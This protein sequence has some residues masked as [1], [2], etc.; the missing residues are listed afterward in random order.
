MGFAQRI[1]SFFLDSGNRALALAFF[2]LLFTMYQGWYTRDTTRRGMRAYVGMNLATIKPMEPV[3]DHPNIF[4]ITTRKDFDLT[5]PQSYLEITII[6]SGST[7]ANRVQSYY[8][9]GTFDALPDSPAQFTQAEA[10][11]IQSSP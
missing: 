9:A 6:N 1:K 11:G 4:K 5:K 10:G 7:P 3:P 8:T 2:T